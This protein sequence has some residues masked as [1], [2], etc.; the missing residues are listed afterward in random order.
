MDYY[1]VGS[2]KG[3]L[4][5]ILLAGFPLDFFKVSDFVTGVFASHLRKILTYE[6]SFFC[7]GLSCLNESFFN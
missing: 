4:L 1:T 2:S 3:L 5:K 6:N 7:N